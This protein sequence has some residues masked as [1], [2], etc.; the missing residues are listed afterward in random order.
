M[1]KIENKTDRCM[2]R[3]WDYNYKDFGAACRAARRSKDLTQQQ[4][5]DAVGVVRSTI[6]KLEHGGY[7]NPMTM[8]RVCQIVGVDLM[9]YNIE[10]ST[11]QQCTREVM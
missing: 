2:F 7:T 11:E 8:W 3:Q 1:S 9:A 4:L 5:A 10:P 6:Y